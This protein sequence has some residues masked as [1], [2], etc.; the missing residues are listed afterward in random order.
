[1][2]EVEEYEDGVDGDSV[3]S[4]TRRSGIFSRSRLVGIAG[5]AAIALGSGA[6]Y[7]MWTPSSPKIVDPAVLAEKKKQDDREKA[8]NAKYD[9]LFAQLTA[10]KTTDVLRELSRANISFR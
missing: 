3:P 10:D 1:M 6:V 7:M 4:L 2:A 9:V 8:K 5:A